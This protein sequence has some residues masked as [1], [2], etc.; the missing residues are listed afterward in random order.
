M[1]C[2][3]LPTLMNNSV[4]CLE[5]VNVSNLGVLFLGRLSLKSHVNQL[6]ALIVAIQLFTLHRKLPTST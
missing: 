5:A 1:I 2:C 3:T 4:L 6:T